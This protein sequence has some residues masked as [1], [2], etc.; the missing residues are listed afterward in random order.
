MDIECQPSEAGSLTIWF[1]V[2]DNAGME[3]IASFSNGVKKDTEGN[4]SSTFS[5]G[6][7]K[8]HKVTL[9]AFSRERDSGLYGCSS[10]IKGKELRFGP[11]TRLFGGEF[12]DSGLERTREKHLNQPKFSSPQKQSNQSPPL[13]TR[14]RV[15]N[16]S[17]L[18][19]RARATAGRARV[20]VSD[21]PQPVGRRLNTL[22]FR[23]SRPFALLHA[24]HPGPAGR[25]LWPS[26]STP[27]RHHFVLQ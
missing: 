11:L 23:G 9:V 16:R 14:L 1:R 17:R 3:F 4:P 27:H 19:Q 12:A 20:S 2:L 24:A 25:R 13:L 21:Q 15:A 6:K 5:Y 7:I 18:L 26:S 10:L 22:S 8:S